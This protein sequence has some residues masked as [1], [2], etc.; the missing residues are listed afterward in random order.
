MLS[1]VRQV[2]DTK[3]LKSVYYANF[4]LVWAQNYN[5]YKENPSEKCSL[6]AEISTQVLYLKTP[7]FLSPVIIQLLKA[8]FLFHI[9]YIFLIQPSYITT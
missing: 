5:Y 8:V 1:K 3:I 4:T 2:L 9:T 7:D 6:G